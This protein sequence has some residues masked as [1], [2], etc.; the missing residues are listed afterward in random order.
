MQN[1]LI[2]PSILAANFLKLG[3]AIEALN[4]S[5]CDW[6]HVDIMDGHFVPEISFGQQI[7]RAIKEISKKPL[8]VHLMVKDPLPKIESFVSAGA[9]R[10]T[11]HLEA[12]HDPRQVIDRIHSFGLPAAISIKPETPVVRLLPYLPEVEMVLVMTV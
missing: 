3:E 12:V 10:L 4:R 8:D 9:D 6:I 5:S 1:I 2:S 7:I 11:F